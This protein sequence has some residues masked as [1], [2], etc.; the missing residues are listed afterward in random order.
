MRLI[1]GMPLIA[2]QYL[3]GIQDT[4]GLLAQLHNYNSDKRYGHVMPFVLDF[5]SFVTLY[6]RF[7]I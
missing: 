4:F 5:R 3:N 7:R 1:T 6:I 2:D